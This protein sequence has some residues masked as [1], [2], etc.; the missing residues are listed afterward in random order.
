MNPRR[1]RPNSSVYWSHSTAKRPNAKRSQST[2]NVHQIEYKYESK[3][4]LLSS[5]SACPIKIH[6]PPT[7]TPKTQIEKSKSQVSLAEFRLLHRQSRPSSLLRKSSLSETQTDKKYLVKGAGMLKSKEQARDSNEQKEHNFSQP[8][9]IEDEID[10]NILV[11]PKTSLVEFRRKKSKVQNFQ[12][13]DLNPN[14][15]IDQYY[16]T[17]KA[18]NKT[19]ATKLKERDRMEEDRRKLKL[20]NHVIKEMKKISDDGPNKSHSKGGNQPIKAQLFFKDY[21]TD[22]A[23]MGTQFTRERKVQIW[24]NNCNFQCRTS[25]SDISNAWTNMI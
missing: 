2:V 18:L 14:Y 12:Y 22:T 3:L 4:R 1:N 16:Y 8:V 17:R 20:A 24:L 5:K 15:L 7:P 25:I 10:E 11:G 13:A 19:E 9:N 21:Y 23:D 6:M